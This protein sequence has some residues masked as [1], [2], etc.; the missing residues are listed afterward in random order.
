MKGAG[1]WGIFVSGDAFNHA[2]R[3][4]THL[5]DA[6]MSVF[7]AIE[8]RTANGLDAF[9]SQAPPAGRLRKGF[10]TDVVALNTDPLDDPKCVARPIA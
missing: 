8:A 4:I 9:G 5:T 3:E 7:D 10:G 2:A 1:S 6:G